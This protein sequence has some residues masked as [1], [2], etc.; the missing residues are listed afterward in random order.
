MRSG[1]QYKLFDE[2]AHF[3]NGLVYRPGFITPEEE[4]ALIVFIESQTL[5]HTYGGPADAY[6]A[7]RRMRHFGWHIDED[8][9]G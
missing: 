4:E 8:E 3:P 9:L 2:P 7:K 5:R 6:E 1:A